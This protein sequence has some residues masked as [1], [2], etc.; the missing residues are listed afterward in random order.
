MD[1]SDHLIWDRELWRTSSLKLKSEIRIPENGRWDLGFGWFWSGGPPTSFPRSP[2][3]V[4]VLHNAHRIRRLRLTMHQEVCFS[5]TNSSEIEVKFNSTSQVKSMV[6]EV[7]WHVFP[8]FRRESWTFF[9]EP[10]G[11]G[12]SIP[13]I[14]YTHPVSL[15]GRLIQS[16]LLPNERG[17]AWISYSAGVI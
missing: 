16:A 1:S 2:H 6:F 12:K 11:F 10:T 5:G 8:W 9:K 15:P 14:G 7:F 4:H 17:S 13:K 3:T